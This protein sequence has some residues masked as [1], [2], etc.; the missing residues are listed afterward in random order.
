MTHTH[1]PAG[2]RALARWLA[3]TAAAVLG[4]ATTASAQSI[5]TAAMNGLVTNASGAPVARATVTVVHK[6]S[7]TKITA[8][9]RAN[10][11]YDFPSLRVGGPYTVTAATPA[12]ETAARENVYLELGDNAEVNLA[13]AANDVVV[14]E[15]FAVIGNRDTIFDNDRMGATAT[16]S[17]GEIQKAPTP[18]NNIQD[19]VRA[20][21]RITLSSLDQGGQMSAQGQNY[22][23]NSFLIDGVEANDPFGLNG[24]GFA[25]LRGP[26]ALDSIESLT[27]E[28][29]PVDPS[30]AGFTGVLINVVTKSGGNEFE[31]SAGYQFKG[32]SI[33]LLGKDIMTRGYRAD[34]GSRQV[35]DSRTYSFTLSGPLIPNKLFFAVSYEDYYQ[36]S[37]PS[38]PLIAFTG[39]ATSTALDGSTKP[40]SEVI[41]E[42]VEYVANTHGYDMGV[43]G[44]G[45][46]DN[47]AK[48]KSY[49]AKID[50]NIT[51]DHR[52]VFSYARVDGTEPSFANYVSA[53]S[54]SASN[55]WFDRPK[56]TNAFTAQVFSQW[57]S[58]FRTEVSLSHNTY[59]GTPTNR[60]APFPYVRIS[61]LG[62]QRA[63][64]SYIPNASLDFGTERSRQMN[65]VDTRQWLGKF[66][67]FYSTGRHS[68][69]AGAEFDSISYSNQYAQDVYGSYTFN[70]AADFM[71]GR[72]SAYRS[73]KVADGFTI[74]DLYANWTYTNYVL[75][76]QDTWRAT[77]RLTL[78]AALRA[79]Y[80]QANKKPLYNEEFHQTFGI[81]NDTTSNGNYL[82]S[83]RFGFNLQLDTAQKTQVRGSLGLYQARSPAVWLSNAYSNAGAG[84]SIT[85]AGG[86]GDGFFSADV[87]NQPPVPGS[88]P[89]P[90]INVTD[91]NFMM[92]SLWK[93]NLA[94]EHKL[95]WGGLVL[96]AEFSAGKVN[97][98]LYTTFL[99][100]KQPASGPQT[101]PDGR[102]RY[103][104]N[105]TPAFANESWGITALTGA[106]YN[107][108]NFQHNSTVL[109][110]GR[111]NNP[112]FADVY[113]IGNTNKGSE[114]GM[115]LSLVRPIKNNWG[116]GI[117]WSRGHA[118][119]V[120]PMTSSVA[121]SNFINR[122]SYNPNENVAATS[123][124]NTRHKI[125]AHASWRHEWKKGWATIAILTYEGLTGHPYSWVF[126]GDANGDGFYNNDLLYVPTGPDD[127][128]VSWNRQGKDGS[129]YLS[130][131]EEAAMRDEFFQFVDSTSLKD[132]K[133]RVMPRN[134]ETSPWSQTFHLT[135]T[136][137][138]PFY[139]KLR[140]ELY[141][142]LINFGNLLN[143]KW[144][145][146]HEVLF[147]YVRPVAGTTYDPNGNN[148][149]GQ[150]QYVFNKNSTLDPVPI[151]SDEVSSSDSIWELVIGFRVKF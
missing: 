86:Y 85:G 146:K 143:K 145:V 13:V 51:D 139:R 84:T 130:P 7:G 97:K 122:A 69:M 64:G 31:G 17:A 59:D 23:H 9:T 70:S 112:N 45:A 4:F 12:N 102:D 106:A 35:F 136:Q 80:P 42:L 88:L 117:A 66:K 138:I 81:R 132:H 151:A 18:R 91:P 53:S 25:T 41:A 44:G 120:S 92:P 16:F 27:V 36:S 19:I 21:P 140:A 142:N 67:S 1:T 141:C 98:G 147:T 128:L 107:A 50:W 20:E 75:Y 82:I 58:D 56:I 46:A 90:N 131:A 94:I 118:T 134:S 77:P 38:T 115:T 83:P 87:N 72:P 68:I 24:N 10:G 14:L 109:S 52:A 61:G 33:S 126:R 99:N 89:A 111:Q 48:Q 96:T 74:E 108:S 105:I 93:G 144:G 2:T 15:R 34:A 100:F 57:T 127:P 76:V 40:S 5:T 121:G 95:P 6:P 114:A 3:A 8:L 124:T 123:N 150:Y 116:A 55:H 113:K 63:D 60:G 110:T 29:N 101:M 32:R 43:I 133:G 28:F 149:K 65:T 47:I 71:A 49:S 22:R 79:D 11:R 62:A 135:L 37:S 137:E 129:W 30:R 119:E 54:I 103:D 73:T 39:T 104:G 148:G 78:Q 26:I 125:V